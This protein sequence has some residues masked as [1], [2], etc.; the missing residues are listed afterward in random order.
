MRVLIADDN[1]SMRQMIRTI[2][3]PVAEEIF[4]CEDGR[5]AV[6][7]YQQIYPDWVLMDFEMPR[8]DGLQA[9]RQIIARNPNARIMLITQH[10]DDDLRIAA[11]EAGATAMVLKDNLFDLRLRASKDAI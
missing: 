4:E 7:T 2:I 11:K 8:L 10:D 5:E 3:Q 6:E 9:I 1:P